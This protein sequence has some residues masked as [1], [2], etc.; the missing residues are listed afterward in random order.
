M[1]HE[2]Q[3]KDRFLEI[4]VDHWVGGEAGREGSDWG[5]SLIKRQLS[6]TSQRPVEKGKCMATK[7]FN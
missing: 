6:L 1:S 4:L 2:I 7:M 5:F 3:T